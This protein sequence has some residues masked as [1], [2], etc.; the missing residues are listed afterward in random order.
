M[1]SVAD[2]CPACGRGPDADAIEVIRLNVE[3]TELHE[4][5][6][7]ARTEVATLE[8]W[9]GDVAGR[10]ITAAARIRVAVRA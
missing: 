3:L 2:G 7:A 5:L 6:R 9:I 1:A 10:R 8:A 4:R